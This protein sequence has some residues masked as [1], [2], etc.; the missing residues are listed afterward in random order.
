MTILW[1]YSMNVSHYLY[2]TALSPWVATMQ[3][4]SS[5]RVDTTVPPHWGGFATAGLA[6]TLGRHITS[7]QTRSMDPP[8]VKLYSNLQYVRFLPCRWCT[9][10]QWQYLANV[11][12]ISRKSSLFTRWGI[13]CHRHHR[14]V[15][16]PSK[17]PMIRG[18]IYFCV[19]V[20]RYSIY[21]DKNIL[22][23]HYAQITAVFAFVIIDPKKV[24][25]FRNNHL[26]VFFSVH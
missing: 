16:F 13:F 8:F 10:N 19:Y 21:S 3:Q 2:T 23:F 20:V 6:K 11:R 26:R 24:D 4:L 12:S 22:V 18:F 7:W 25:V 15:G 5:L 1:P 17:A 9:L 14:S